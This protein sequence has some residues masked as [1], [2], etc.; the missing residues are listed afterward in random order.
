[1][2]M[3]ISSSGGVTTGKAVTIVRLLDSGRTRVKG[4][5]TPD[6]DEA[7]TTPPVT[8]SVDK[9][10]IRFTIIKDD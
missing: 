6:S 3:H 8:E 7:A 9:S 1:M 2:V 10:R 4:V 5:D